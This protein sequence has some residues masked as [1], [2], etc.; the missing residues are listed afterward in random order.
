LEY[1]LADWC[2]FAGIGKEWGTNVWPQRSDLNLENYPIGLAHV[3][4][5]V[6]EAQRSEESLELSI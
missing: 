4:Q 5:S 2:I 3:T 1:G 6:N